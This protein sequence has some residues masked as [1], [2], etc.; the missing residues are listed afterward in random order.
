M[1]FWFLLTWAFPAT[2]G[3]TLEA[4][5]NLATLV[6]KPPVHYKELYGVR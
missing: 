5:F 2:L 1:V 3:N 4:F 6:V